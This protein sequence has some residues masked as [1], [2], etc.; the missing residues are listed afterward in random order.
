MAEKFSIDVESV[1]SLTFRCP[2]FPTSQNRVAEAPNL[3]G[4]TECR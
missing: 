3:V 1:R 2:G 4:A